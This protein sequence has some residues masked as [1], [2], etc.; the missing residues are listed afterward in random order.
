[1][2][3][4]SPQSLVFGVLA[5]QTNLVTR[6][7]LL[8]ALRSWT[9]EASPL[10]EVLV[11]QHAL[12]SDERQLLEALAERH[13]R[14]FEDN[15]EQCLAALLATT[16]AREVIDEWEAETLDPH[17]TLTL[18][19]GQTSVGV[20]TSA[21]GRFQI[22][23]P[24]ARGGLG[25]V[26]LA[27]DTELNREVALKQM[28]PRGACHAHLRS[29]F[30]LEAEVTG[31][32]EH[33]SI[34]PVYGLGAYEDGRPYYVM[35]L[36]RG[37][38]LKEA[39]EKL[40]RAPRPANLQLRQLLTRLMSICDA[41]AYAHSRGVVH[42]D[43]KPGNI[44]LG[45][46]GE[47]LL[48][49]WGLAKLLRMQAEPAEAS[50]PIVSAAADSAA[51]QEGSIVG[52]PA[53]MS[54]EQAAGRLDCVGP[55]SDICSLGATLY[56]LLTGRPPV[57]EPDPEVVLG[58]VQKGLFPNPRAY[59][60]SIPRPLEAICLK[61][62]SLRPEDRYQSASDLK[63]DLEHW[64]ADEPVAAYRERIGERVTRWTRKH[65]G[66]TRVA[67]IALFTIAL[68]SI[69]ATVF[70]DRERRR[71]DDNARIAGQQRDA[72]EA[73]RSIAEAERRQAT[74]WGG[75][76]NHQRGLALAIL[77]S[78]VFELQARLRDR[79]GM[80]NLREE[81]LSQSVAKLEQIA[82]TFE[83]GWQPPP[84]DFAGPEHERGYVEG[85]ASSQHMSADLAKAVA[86]GQMGDILRSAGRRN[87]AVRRYD[88]G[89]AIMLAIWDGQPHQ[90]ETVRPF[91]ANSYDRLGHSQLGLGSLAAAHREYAEATKL[92][93][94]AAAA[95]PADTLALRELARTY[96]LVGDVLFQQQRLPL[97]YDRYRRALA[98]S[99]NAAELQPL[100]SDPHAISWLLD[101]LGSSALRMGNAELARGFYQQALD[102]REQDTAR[103]GTA[104]HQ[105]SL[106][107]SYVALGN[108]CVRLE[109]YPAAR[110]YFLK[111]LPLREA[112]LAADPLSLEAQRDLRVAFNRL[113]HVATM[114]NE[115]ESARAYVR[116]EIE[117][118]KKLAAVDASGTQAQTNL[119]AAYAGLALLETKS[120]NPVEAARAAA[121]AAAA[122]LPVRLSGKSTQEPLL[123]NWVERAL[124]RLDPR[125]AA[126]TSTSDLPPDTP[127]AA[128]RE[129]LLLR[130]TVLSSQGDHFAAIEAAEQLYALSSSDGEA[131]YDATRCFA[132]ADRRDRA[133]AV[134]QQAADAGFTNWQRMQTDPDLS[135]LREQAAY[136]KLFDRL[137]TG[138]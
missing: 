111:A 19:D 90:R 67:G 20:R 25:E 102:Q 8:A 17:A 61:A 59:A 81:L 86:L 2:V 41:L 64:L 39:I 10:G 34:V 126:L 113:S 80:Q 76:A 44:M 5:Y 43:I 9:P 47:T 71:A 97:A 99:R 14:R 93:E 11:E 22:L 114:L 112:A 52:T 128:A 21:G 75:V 63:D 56:I 6:E 65:R 26:L 7:R 108:S 125:R 95:R 12:S 82:E 68:I 49:D 98:M 109:D 123:P 116:R 91:L 130:S 58:R 120:G 138:H 122:D 16:S 53:Y 31:R 29:R 73:A 46:F 84:R 89:H 132:L 100:P 118:A 38:S 136:R 92:R 101:D 106:S 129:L 35:R 1:M 133:L 32:L 51:T 62:M 115:L 42:R 88:Q 57:A 103:F 28:Q 85:F 48:V 87:D 24:Y 36:I 137:S 135:T 33:P 13:L 66:A 45:P 79:P 104:T 23:R 70:V 40:H 72:A 55:A 3:R 124:Q 78:L 127:P 110:E 94:A 121:L 37:E 18:G 119:A 77:D 30:V 54:P 27:M 50:G 107:K 131:L 83:P 117:L 105:A 15:A 4:A 96:R 74:Q 69:V 134:L 60:P